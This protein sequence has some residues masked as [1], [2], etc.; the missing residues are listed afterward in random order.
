MKYLPSWKRLCTDTEVVRVEVIP[1]TEVK[2][3]ISAP[4]DLFAFL[5]SSLK[6]PE[7]LCTKSRVGKN[8]WALVH[9]NFRAVTN[10]LMKSAVSLCLRKLTR[11]SIIYC[12]YLL[13]FSV[14]KMWNIFLPYTYCAIK[15]V[16]DGIGNGCETAL[17]WYLKNFCHIDFKCRSINLHKQ[18]KE[19]TKY[20]DQGITPLILCIIF[21]TFVRFIL[22]KQE[23]I[24]IKNCLWLFFSTIIFKWNKHFF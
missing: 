4:S 10:L 7:C 6:L 19:P 16:C 20:R 23:D 13:C 21:F 12:N 22:S 2:E 1:Y 9:K 24:E 17:S 3:K 8:E 14:T 5:Y 11:L 18:R 15:F